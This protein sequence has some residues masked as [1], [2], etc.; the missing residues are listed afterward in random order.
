MPQE[1]GMSDIVWKS[2]KVGPSEGDWKPANYN[3]KL[4]FA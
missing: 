1:K 3:V 2:F 4:T